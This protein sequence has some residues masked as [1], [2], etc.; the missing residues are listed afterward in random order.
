MTATGSAPRSWAAPTEAER[1]PGDTASGTDASQ[2]A[3]HEKSVGVSRR[4]T[5]RTLQ[6][7]QHRGLREAAGRV[8]G[9]RAHRPALGTRSF[10]AK[11][12]RISVLRP[13]KPTHLGAS[14]SDFP[15]PVDEDSASN[16]EPSHPPWKDRAETPGGREAGEHGPMEKFDRRNFPAPRFRFPPEPF[17]RAAGVSSAR[18]PCASSRRAP[19]LPLAASS[20]RARRRRCTPVQH[21]TPVRHTPVTPVTPVQGTVQHTVA[22]R[23]SPRR[24]CGRSWARRRCPEVSARGAP[25]GLPT[26][27]SPMGRHTC[28][29]GGCL[30]PNLCGFAP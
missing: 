13:L 27:G 24:R 16:P 4:K 11:A 6:G 2:G 23:R 22:R 10:P 17:S 14:P 19:P 9:R 26:A 21:Q 30:P 8:L 20:R 29:G 25:L 7:R 18:R 12:R 5:P 15:R 1:L 3:A 28:R